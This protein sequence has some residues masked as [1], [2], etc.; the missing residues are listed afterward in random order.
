MKG[1]DI[2]ESS[3]MGLAIIAEAEPRFRVST[4]QYHAS[5]EAKN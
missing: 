4:D 5:Y 1:F 3:R 2:L